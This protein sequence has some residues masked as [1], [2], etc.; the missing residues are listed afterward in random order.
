MPAHEQSQPVITEESQH[1]HQEFISRHKR[2]KLKSGGRI[3]LFCMHESGAYERLE[4]A[5]RREESMSAA[6]AA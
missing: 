2:G 3:W 4:E 1:A 6:T 5:D